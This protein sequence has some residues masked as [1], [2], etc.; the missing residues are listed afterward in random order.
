MNKKI[1]AVF[2]VCAALNCLFAGDF[3]TGTVDA[4]WLNM[5]IK[6]GINEAVVGKIK[7][8]R[9]VQITR[10]VKNWLEIN[11]PED[12]KIFVAVSRINRNGVVTGELNMRTA[13]DTQSPILGVLT[14]GTKVEMTGS[15]KHGWVQIKKPESVDL[16]VYVSAFLVK[17]DS[18]KFDAN[19][20]IISEFT[21]KYTEVI[22]EK[23][24]Y[25]ILSILLNVVDWGTGNRI[26]RAPYNI[27]AQTG[28]KTG[29]T[30]DNADGWFMAFTPQLVSGVWVGGEERYIHFNSMAQGQGASMALPIYGLY[31]SKVYADKSLPYS[32]DITFKFPSHID[33]CEKE[34]FGEEYTET[35]EGSI[36]GVFD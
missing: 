33:L 17:Y 22:S 13:M 26:R 21:P 16:K 3:V 10:V 34:D 6:P 28:G 2:A 31:M 5:R 18:S 11:A 9:E 20:N 15:I 25:R 30:N 23:A 8:K 7:E 4:D 27:T 32:Q 24:Y 35:T 29:T 36:E 14:K 12:L 1:F 19:G